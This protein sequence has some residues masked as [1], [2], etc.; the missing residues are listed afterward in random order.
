MTAPPARPAVPASHGDGEASRQRGRVLVVEDDYIVGLE[1]EAGLTDAG[2]EVVGV[3]MTAEQALVLATAERPALV[4]MDVRL[5]GR[6]DGI[7]AAKDILQATGARS[8][9]ATATLHPEIQVRAAAARPLGWI[10]K[11][12]QVEDLAARIRR[13]LAESP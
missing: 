5:G 10:G 2:F 11:P 1:L 7:E 12:Y 13:I 6:R 3:A 4:V 8:I 9:F